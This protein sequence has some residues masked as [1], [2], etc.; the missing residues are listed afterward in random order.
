MPTFFRT[1]WLTITTCLV[2]TLI[3]TGVSYYFVSSAAHEGEAALQ[4]A[5]EEITTAK[6]TLE[7]FSMDA[8][9]AKGALDKEK[10]LNAELKK[11]LAATEQEREGL[12]GSL[13]TMTLAS[14]KAAKTKTSPVAASTACRDKT[15]AAEKDLQNKQRALQALQADVYKRD[16]ELRERQKQLDETLARLAEEKRKLERARAEYRWP[17]NGTQNN[18]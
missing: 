16:S 12:R 17:H 5:E 10:A 15:A 11:I 7:K 14:S 3:A 6:A 2:Y 4:K 18:K 8:A 1:H 9:K 13:E